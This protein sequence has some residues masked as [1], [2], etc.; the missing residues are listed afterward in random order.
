MDEVSKLFCSVIN[1]FLLFKNIPALFFL[2]MAKKKANE[3][4]LFFSKF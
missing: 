3:D 4:V 1:L 2:E